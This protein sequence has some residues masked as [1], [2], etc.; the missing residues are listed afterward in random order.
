MVGSRYQIPLE[1]VIRFDPVEYQRVAQRFQGVSIIIDAFE[2]YRLVHCRDSCIDEPFDGEAS[3]FGQL[4][5][6]IELGHQIKRCAGMR[7]EHIHQ[8]LG[9]AHRITCRHAGTEPDDQVRP[10]G[11]ESFDHRR[12]ITV[13]KGEDIPP[14]KQYLLDLGMLSHIG[15]SFVYL[16][17]GSGTLEGSGESSTEAMPAVH[18]TDVGGQESHPARVPMDQAVGYTVIDLG[19]RIQIFLLDEDLFCIGGNHLSAKRVIGIVRI[20]E[21]EKIGWDA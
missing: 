21:V 14:G 11:A 3:L 2:Q 19:Q 9:D 1:E 7:F 17:R 4:P 15:G 10:F 13:R 5:G 6:V 20:D 8:S 18:G 16:L 12:K